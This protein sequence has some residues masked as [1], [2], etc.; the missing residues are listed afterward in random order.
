MPACTSGMDYFATLP[1]FGHHLFHNVAIFFV[2][3]IMKTMNIQ[4]RLTILIP[5]YNIS[6]YVDEILPTYAKEELVGKI[7]VFL[8]DDGSTDDTAEKIAP[9]VQKYPNLF[10]Y[11]HK[12]N[13]GHGSVI[14]YGLTLVDTPYFKVID[15][16]DWTDSKE[17]STLLQALETL[18]AD[19]F[20]TDYTEA[21]PD[22]QRRI[23]SYHEANDGRIYA[24]NAIYDES[25][26]PHFTLGIHTL[27]FK[28]ALWKEN[29]LQVR[30]H[31]YYEDT[32]YCAY[33]L[34]Y[35]KRFVYVPCN[36]YF[37]RLGSQGQSVSLNSFIRHYADA[38][39]VVHDLYEGYDELV[40]EKANPAVLDAY[41]AIAAKFTF[42]ETIFY[43]EN[44]KM[45]RKTCL[46][47]W[48]EMKKRP[49]IYQKVLH[50]SKTSRALVFARF[51]CLGLFR[52]LIRK[53]AH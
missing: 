7:K 45:A 41:A 34:R 17:L 6:K 18:D 21:Y 5:S 13:G 25:I 37:Y 46:D 23:V 40:T 10:F 49:L 38:L 20:V 27:T 50:Q 28:T 44:K 30:E 47:L 15:G 42:R 35:A 32:E 39:K 36:V 14:N 51:R 33:P 2:R 22:H 11:F 1:P 31:V 9:W 16:D 52:K 43:P 24:P 8:I 12:E 53:R 48:K 3:F 26:L 29:H 19:V 4:P